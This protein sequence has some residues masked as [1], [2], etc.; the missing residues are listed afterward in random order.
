MLKS[1]NLKTVKWE[2]MNKYLI[3]E[4]KKSVLL[5]TSIFFLEILYPLPTYIFGYFVVPFGF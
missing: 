4:K 1:N 3:I 2:I 5:F